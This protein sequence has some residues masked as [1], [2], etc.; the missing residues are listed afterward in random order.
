VYGGAYDTYHRPLYAARPW[1]PGIASLGWRSWTLGTST[2][3][4]PNSL[5]IQVGFSMIRYLFLTPA[6]PGFDPFTFDFDTDPARLAASGAMIDATSTDV[7]AFRQRGGK[8]I[9][10]TGAADPVFSANDLAAYYE[11]LTEAQ[12]GLASTQRFARLFLVPGMNHCSAG[13]SLDRFDALTSIVRWVEKGRAPARLVATGAT[14]PGRSRP[15][16]PYP[17]EAH[18]RGRGD[19][20]S[21]SSFRCV[22]PDTAPE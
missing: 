5:D 8:L 2:T 17:A 19:E 11:R 3:A 9:M 4:E 20:E 10:Y 16:C 6:E 7:N 21:A 12:G 14:F 18:Y 13:P 1:D 15:L 22:R